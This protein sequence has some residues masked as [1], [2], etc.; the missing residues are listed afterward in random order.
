MKL[1]R[2]KPDPAMRDATG[3]HAAGRNWFGS[4]LLHL[5]VPVLRVRPRAFLHN[6][7]FNKIGESAVL[8]FC[9]LV[10]GPLDL[11]RKCHVKPGFE[12]FFAHR[13]NTINIECVM[14]QHF[15][16]FIFVDRKLMPCV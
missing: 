2:V 14:C 13:E 16:S 10:S 6:Q 15:L 7:A 4:C 11:R 3:C 8:G 1:C 5:S 9:K 12:A